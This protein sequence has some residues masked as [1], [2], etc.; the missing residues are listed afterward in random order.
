MVV[1]IIYTDPETK[2]SGKINVENQTLEGETEQING[3]YNGTKG[4]FKLNIDFE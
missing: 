4:T 3:L 1:D 2:F